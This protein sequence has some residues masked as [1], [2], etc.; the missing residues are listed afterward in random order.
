M[1][2]SLLFGA[3]EKGVGQAKRMKDSAGSEFCSQSV[4]AGPAGPLLLLTCG[5]DASG[6][7][8]GCLVPGPCSVVLGLAVCLASSKATEGGECSG[9]PSDGQVLLGPGDLCSSLPGG[10]CQSPS[11]LGCP[12]LLCSTPSD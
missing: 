7:E 2:L 1:S 10:A 3:L 11:V 12:L 6:R 5:V 4:P 8:S 9:G